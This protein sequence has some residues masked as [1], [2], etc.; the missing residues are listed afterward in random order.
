MCLTK[1]KILM[2]SKRQTATQRR[3]DVVEGDDH[4][5]THQPVSNG[6]RIKLDHLKT[7]DPLTENQGKFF[8]MYRG[9][10][11]FI[12]LFGS[13]GVGKTFLAM[14][15]AL[16]EVL[17][18]DNPFKQVVVIRSTVAV[19]DMGFLPGSVEEKID[20]YEQPYKEICQTLFGRPD[21]W[22]R[23]KEQSYA[24]FIPTSFVRGIS[25]DDAIIIVDEAQNMTWSELSS[26]MGRVGYRSKIIFAGD[27]FQN[28][29]VRSKNDVSGL[30]DF[31]S[32]AK[33]MPEFEAVYFTPQ[34]IVRSSLVKSFIMACDS[35]GKMP[36]H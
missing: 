16:E 24:R 29:L 7:F 15:K 35:K 3:E 5:H 1:E 28:D 14:Y 19:R 31:L 9:G 6:L 26:I 21:A 33:I 4:K 11:Y 25:I 36:G 8:E 10:G 34:D 22:E 27:K 12:G 13:P 30:E 2:A 18:K 32:I 23:L 17:S 20:I